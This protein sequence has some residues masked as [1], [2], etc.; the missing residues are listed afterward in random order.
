MLLK[1]RTNPQENDRWGPVVTQDDRQ[2]PPPS[3]PAGKAG[4]LLIHKPINTQ[5][6]ADRDLWQADILHHGPDNGQAT[7]FCCE[8]V[9]LIRTLPN[10]AKETFNGVGSTDVAMHDRWKGIKGQKMLFIFDQA[11]YG[12]RIALLLFGFEG[13]QIE[14]SVF[15]LLLLEDPSQFG[16]DLFLLTMGNG[17]H[18]IAL[19]VNETALAQRH[20]KQRGDR[21]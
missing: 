9:N 14:K 17:V 18:H 2:T 20:R 4:W 10:I 6:L 21:R 8:G 1:R 19:F 15:F 12:L 3:S 5:P 13:R 11:A 7:A 16:R